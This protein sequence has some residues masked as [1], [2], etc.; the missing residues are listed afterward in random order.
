[1]GRKHTF[2]GVPLWLQN[3]RTRAH[4]RVHWADG[5]LS[6]DS[7]PDVMDENNVL[8]V[9]DPPTVADAP[10]ML[11]TGTSREACAEHLAETGSVPLCQSPRAKMGWSSTPP[12]TRIA[13]RGA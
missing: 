11:C 10:L 13:A 3:V 8:G 1:M 2:D 7:L 6:D 12:S 9:D 4:T 5:A